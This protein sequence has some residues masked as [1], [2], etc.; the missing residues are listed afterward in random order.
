[1]TRNP[2]LRTLIAANMQSMTHIAE[3]VSRGGEYEC[4]RIQQTEAHY[5]RLLRERCHLLAIPIS[6]M[7][8]RR[9]DDKH[10]N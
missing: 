2:F 4:L 8:V 6:R 3:Y 5:A 9:Y 7:E 1:M 10:S